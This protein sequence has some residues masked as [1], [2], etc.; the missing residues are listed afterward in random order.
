M[1]SLFACV[2][3]LVLAACA[4]IPSRGETQATTPNGADALD[5]VTLNLWHDKQDWPRRQDLIVRELEQRKPDVVLL[6][7]VLQDPGL[8]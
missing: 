6:Q 4:R 7:E 8:V 1:K 2:V 3:A 5:V